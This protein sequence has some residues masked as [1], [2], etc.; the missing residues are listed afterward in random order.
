MIFNLD[1]TIK[2]TFKNV[3]DPNFDCSSVVDS[4]GYKVDE[5][6]LKQVTDG[7][8]ST[9]SDRLLKGGDLNILKNNSTY[10][11]EKEKFN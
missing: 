4:T 5:I 1:D 10:I 11:S 8:Y 3:L 2:N 6:K 7:Y 9:L